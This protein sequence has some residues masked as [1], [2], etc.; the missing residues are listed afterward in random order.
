MGEQEEADVNRTQG[1]RKQEAEPILGEDDDHNF[2]LQSL[3]C[4]ESIQ[5]RCA[6]LHINMVPGREGWADVIELW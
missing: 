4:V 3:R 1:T 2:G 5:G 6:I